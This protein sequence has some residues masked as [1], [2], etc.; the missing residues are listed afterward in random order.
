M[1]F[2][3]KKKNAPN[4]RILFVCALLAT[5]IVVG[6][7]IKRTEVGT[8]VWEKTHSAFIATTLN[9]NPD[10]LVTVGNYYFND[11]NEH[12]YNLPKAKKYFLKA[13]K[14]DERV[15]DAWHQLARISFL[16]GNYPE[17]LF[18]IN[19][20]IY[21]HGRGLMSAYYMR[22]LIYGYAGKYKEAQENFIIF[23]GWDQKN[24]A[25]HNDLAWA[26][27]QGGRYEEAYVI[28]QRGL[29]FNPENP[30]LLNMAGVALLNQGKKKE[31][32]P[33]FETALTNMKTLTPA[34]WVRAY[35]GNS[36][37]IAEQGLAETIQAIEKNLEKSKT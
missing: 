21:F 32:Q 33:L 30:W 7:Y 11:T 9:Q 4:V 29:A 3:F 20:Q 2:L 31:A 37:A 27:F 34:A 5:L 12:T 22:G 6:V 24:W 36:P 8:F 25:A 16:E 26:Y 15:R 28:A 17:A 13:V 1:K 14:K 18:Y 19:N 23:L 10:F 35:P